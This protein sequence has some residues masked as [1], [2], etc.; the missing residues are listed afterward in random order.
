MQQMNI[1]IH[2]KTLKKV[3]EYYKELKKNGAKRLNVY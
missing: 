1:F 3:G 2:L